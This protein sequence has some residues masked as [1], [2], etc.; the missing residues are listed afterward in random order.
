MAAAGVTNS[1]TLPTGNYRM[2]HPSAVIRYVVAL[3]E[4]LTTLPSSSSFVPSRYKRNSPTTSL[5]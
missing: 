4:V 3:A 2:C 1:L 5:K